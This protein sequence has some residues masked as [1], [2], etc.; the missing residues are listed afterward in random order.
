MPKKRLS[1]TG[2]AN[3]Y[4]AT[5]EG[6]VNNDYAGTNNRQTIEMRNIERQQVSDAVDMADSDQPGVMHLLARHG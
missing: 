1:P 4:A 6:G 5:F 3:I 2:Q